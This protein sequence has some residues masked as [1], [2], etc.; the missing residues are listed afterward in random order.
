MKTLIVK[1]P[2]GQF[3]QFTH[4]ELTTVKILSVNQGSSLSLQQHNHR[5]EFWRVISGHPQV[6]VGNDTIIANPGDEFIIEVLQLHRLE[7]R[8]DDV[9]VLEIAF[10][11]FDESDIIRIKDKYGRA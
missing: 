8:E 4:N 9:Q 5:T 1:K 7:A 10:G 6:T 11:D 2:W 3:D